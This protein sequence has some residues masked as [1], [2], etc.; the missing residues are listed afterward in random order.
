M[1]FLSAVIILL[2]LFAFVARALSL[3]CICSTNDQLVFPIII[4]ILR[5]VASSTTTGDTSGPTDALRAT[6]TAD[7]GT[8]STSGDV[9]ARPTYDSTIGGKQVVIY[10]YLLALNTVIHVY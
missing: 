6:E 1:V 4:M 7:T 3:H 10:N 2:S 5:F 9:T 8:P